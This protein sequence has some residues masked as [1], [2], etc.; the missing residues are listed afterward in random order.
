MRLMNPE[1]FP[2]L[3]LQSIAIDSA[4]DCALGNDY[5]E[6]G[7][8]EFVRLDQHGEARA[9]ENSSP[10]NQCGNVSS[11]EPLPV[12][13]SLAVAQTLRR[14]RPLARRARRIAR[15]PRVRMRTRN[16]WVRFL[17]ITEG[18]NVRFMKLFPQLEQNIA[19]DDKLGKLVK[20]LSFPPLWITL[21]E[22]GKIRA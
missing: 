8:P 4:R 3:P 22:Q 6:S 13:I 21:D 7:D 16:P 15:P 18:W 20:E 12:A 2:K 11:P 10:G 5:I 17:R 9:S 1:P 14:A 19:L